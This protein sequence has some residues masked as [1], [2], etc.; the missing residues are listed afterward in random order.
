MKL[1]I[2]LMRLIGR[3]FMLFDDGVYFCLNDLLFCRVMF[4]VLS[5]LFDE[6]VNNR[7]FIF[8]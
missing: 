2:Y 1:L 7:W 6:K 8:V 3:Y 4:W 5:G